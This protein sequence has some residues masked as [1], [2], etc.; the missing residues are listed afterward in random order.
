MA[1]MQIEFPED[2]LFCHEMDIRIDDVNYGGHLGH[3]RVVSLLHE[4][5]VCFFRSF[6]ASELDTDGLPLMIVELAV[7]Y[8]GE[9][10]AGQR[11]KIEIGAGEVA[12]RRADL[13]YRVNEADQDRIIALAR[14]RLVFYD[15]KKNRAALV[16]STFRGA[17]GL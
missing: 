5:R 12:S 17:L 11:L 7:S 2:V 4:A 16:P 10:F 13:L 1:R 8:R 9:G 6:G 14:T 15:R 3:D